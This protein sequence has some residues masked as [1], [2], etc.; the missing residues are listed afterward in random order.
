MKI[1]L[2]SLRL[3][4]QRHKNLIEEN[5]IEYQARFS[6]GESFP[7]VY[8]HFDGS[9]YFMQDGFHRVEAARREGLEEID[10]EVEPG[11][12]EEMEAE[13]RE[14]LEELLKSLRIPQ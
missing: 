5:V 7:P 9:D 11:T 2:S 14:M 10:C 12:I 6:N 4:F 3:D 8:V 13:Y 1:K